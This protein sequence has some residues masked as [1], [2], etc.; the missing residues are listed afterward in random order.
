MH[1][2]SARPTIPPSY[3]RVRAVV[4]WISQS[5]W[6]LIAL[7]GLWVDLRGQLCVRERAWK[8]EGMS[9]V[10]GLEGGEGFTPRDKK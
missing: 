1:N 5:H 3:I 7:P 9:K 4:F 6:E 8:G 2:Q 10:K